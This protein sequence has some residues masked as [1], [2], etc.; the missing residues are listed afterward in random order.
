MT[1]RPALRGGQC[2]LLAACLAAC[3][4][5]DPAR[6]A[7]RFAQRQASR[8]PAE[9]QVGDLRIYAS[10]AP[11]TALGPAITERYGIPPAR[12]AHLLLVGLRRGEAH[13]DVAVAGSVVARARDLRGVWQQIDL[14]E[15]RV[16][17]FVDYV[18]TVH[19]MPPDTLSFEIVA[20]ADDDADPHVLQFS[21]DIFP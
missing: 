10:L 9:L 11:T 3:G 17:G 18:G 16:D 8:A 6:D 13:A 15:T 12:D 1:E 4:G 5:S 21:R 2:V 7:D 20:R 14:R 19:A